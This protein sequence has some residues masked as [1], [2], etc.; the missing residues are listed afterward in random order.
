MRFIV[1]LRSF[2]HFVA[3]VFFVLISPKTDCL[4]KRS[5]TGLKSSYFQ[6][7]ILFQ[8]ENGH[9]RT[10][11]HLKISEK[12]HEIDS[13]LYYRLWYVQAIFYYLIRLISQFFQIYTALICYFTK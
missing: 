11:G 13:L 4:S 8:W 12:K 1:F 10:I 5:G 9:D 3:D 7:I 2:A 6:Q